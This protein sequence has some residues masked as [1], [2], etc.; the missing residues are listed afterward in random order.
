MN[1][2]SLNPCRLGLFRFRA[3]QYS[4]LICSLIHKSS[5]FARFIKNKPRLLAITGAF[6]YLKGIFSDM[7]I[8]PKFDIGFLK[9]QRNGKAKVTTARSERN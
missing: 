6:M 5:C 9:N 1:F 2:E 3:E 8:L 4:S 7:E